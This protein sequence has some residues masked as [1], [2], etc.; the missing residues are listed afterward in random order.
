MNTSRKA[1]LRHLAAHRPRRALSVTA[2]S[3]A[4]AIG[5]TD[6]AKDLAGL[7]TAG[8]VA[9]D[10]GWGLTAKG[11]DHVETRMADEGV[12]PGQIKGDK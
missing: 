4:C 5:R 2:I 12:T 10:R 6:A 11:V 1:I 8:L 9:F 7:E 3:T